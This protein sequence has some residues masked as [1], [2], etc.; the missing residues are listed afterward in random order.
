MD[1]K[2]I[3]QLLVIIVSE[4]CYS[5]YEQVRRDDEEELINDDPS[6][7]TVVQ[8]SYTVANSFYKRNRFN[9]F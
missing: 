3:L 6:L 4:I 8:L 2:K 1:V 7:D 5:N 9:G